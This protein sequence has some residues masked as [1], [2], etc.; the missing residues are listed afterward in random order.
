MG[1]LRTT[2]R[3]L[4]NVHDEQMRMWEA[5]YRVSTWDTR[6]DAPV[7]EPGPA[8]AG[9]GRPASRSG[10]R[11]QRSPGSL[12][13]ARQAEQAR[14]AATEVSVRAEVTGVTAVSAAAGAGGG[15]RSL[16]VAW[17]SG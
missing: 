13:L 9:P 15:S 14:P 12:T 2:L 4:R 8:R 3:A 7:R 17:L 6:P 10:G 11:R 16:R 5:F 1:A